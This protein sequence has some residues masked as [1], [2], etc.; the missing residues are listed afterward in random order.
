[1]EMIQD[2]DLDDHCVTVFQ[3]FS[4]SLA[5]LV[6]CQHALCDACV[7]SCVHCNCSSSSVCNACIRA[8]YAL[9]LLNVSILAAV[10]L[11]RAMPPFVP[12]RHQYGV[13]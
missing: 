2:T 12:C 10:S 3:T 13:L 11:L 1:M 4:I 7:R 9:R 8:V 5:V 6:F